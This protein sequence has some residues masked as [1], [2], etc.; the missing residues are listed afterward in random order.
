MSRTLDYARLVRLPNVFTALADICLGFVVTLT[1]GETNRL[2]RFGLLLLASA[3]LYMAGMV[4]NDYFDI[5]QD[6]RE[7]PFRPLAS[8]RVALSMGFALGCL[9]LAAGLAAALGADL[10]RPDTSF[11]SLILAGCLTAAILAYDGVFKRTW[12]GPIFMGLCRF[13]NILLGLSIVS[14]APNWGWLLAVVVGLYVAGVTWFARTEAQERSSVQ[15]LKGAAVVMLM[16]VLLSL[17][18]PILVERSASD[19]A[20]PAVLFPYLLAGFIVV[21]GWPVMRAIAAPVPQRVQSAVK[22]AVLGLVL[23]DAVLATSVVG[24]VGLLIG[25]L[26]LP[27]LFVGRRV[28]ST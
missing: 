11:R 7:R 13:L 23:L 22:R 24:V 2:E 17:A 6:R 15:S 27:A 28:Y 19:A 3:C 14:Q 4:W 8:G 10:L 1:V 20:A 5:E 16:G 9:Q 25:L 26:V 21:I 12:A 18:A